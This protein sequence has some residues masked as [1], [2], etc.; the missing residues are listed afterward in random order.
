M[1]TS[2]RAAPAGP[3]RRGGPDG[4]GA[5]AVRQ[6]QVVGGGHGLRR[7]PDAGRM[8]A[9]PVAHVRDHPRLV[10]RDPPANPVAQGAGH[11]PGVVGEEISGVP[12]RPAALVLQCLRQVPVVE[13]HQRGDPALQ[14]RVHE[15]AVVRQAGR[16]RAAPAVRLD[17]RPGDG[18]PVSAGVQLGRQG[19]VLLE[20]VVVVARDVPGVAVRGPPGLVAERV[21]DRPAFP[22]LAGRAL[23]LVGGGRHTPQ[24]SRREGVTL[25]AVRW[26]HPI[27][28]GSPISGVSVDTACMPF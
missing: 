6:Q 17:A 12:G 22:V 21:P 24:E 8:L 23:D 3:G 1:P 25:L 4:G 27:L 2:V 14:Q 16:V 9:P 13:R 7:A 15:P 19:D 28:L 11:D 20:P 5:A 18:E 10:D 26:T